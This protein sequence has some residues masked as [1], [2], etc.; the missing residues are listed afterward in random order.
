MNKI[1]AGAAL[2]V[3]LALAGAAQATTLVQVDF[4]GTLTSGSAAVKGPFNASGSGI[5]QGMSVDG[6]FVYDKDLVTGAGFE[7]VAFAALTDPDSAFQFDIGGLSYD[8]GDATTGAIGIAPKILFNNG[9]FNG[10]NF[11]S[12]FVYTDSLDYRLRFNS[13]SFEIKRVDP[14]TGFNV[15][16]TVFVKGN[17]SSELTNERAFVEPPTGPGGVPE[18]STWALLILGFGASGAALRRRR[19]LAIA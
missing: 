18:P 10:F 11:V 4:S 5:T 17:L 16:S 15:N 13:R 8:L 19:C 9:V 2:A 14:V 1:I 7:L 12:D 6:T 3:G